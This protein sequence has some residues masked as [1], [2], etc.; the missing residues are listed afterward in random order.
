MSAA[1]PWPE[2]A[3]TVTEDPDRVGVV[4]AFIASKTLAD[5]TG[6]RCED[7]LVISGAFVAVVDG[8]SSPLRVATEPPTG[9][10]FAR[11]IGSAI[12]HLPPARTP[13]AAVAD[14]TEAVAAIRPSHRGPSGAVVA[15]VSLARREVWRVGDVHVRV[16]DR[17]LAGTK[18]VDEV[19]A[20]YR[21]LVNHAALLGGASIEEIRATDPGLE[22]LGPLL[23]GQEQFANRSGEF[24]Y[25][26]VDGTTVPAAHIEVVPVPSGAVDVVLASDGFLSAAPSLAVAEAELDLALAGDPACL[27]AELRG[28][29]KAVAPGATHPDDRSYVR[30]RLPPIDD[31]RESCP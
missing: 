19:G 11:T 24:G 29:G 22:S 25:G 2:R 3:A 26:V 20:G 31:A 21:A 17:H 18:V 10:R 9:A 5:T 1:G 14:L 23:R 8:M 12:A 13:S 30:V 4:D 28:M 7:H 16:G 27:G 6:S 15:I